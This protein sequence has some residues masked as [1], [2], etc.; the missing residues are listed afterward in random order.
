MRDSLKLAANRAS[1]ISYVIDEKICIK[2]A[3]AMDALWQIGPTSRQVYVYNF[4]SDYLVD[5]PT[6][7][8]DSEYRGL[9]V[10]TRQWTYKRTFLSF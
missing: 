4:G 7:G 2:A 3:A 5:D 6:V 9:Q 10:F 1:D 8:R